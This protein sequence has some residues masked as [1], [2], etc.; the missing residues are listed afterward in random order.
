M[1]TVFIGGL[2]RPQLDAVRREFPELNIIGATS[3]ESGLAWKRSA[4]SADV[5][6][7]SRFCSHSQLE[8]LRE[9]TNKKLIHAHGGGR[10]RE[11]LRKLA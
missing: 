7:V 1:L 8:C 6:L 9:A 2:L 11:E 4:S 3:Q 5:L 10:L